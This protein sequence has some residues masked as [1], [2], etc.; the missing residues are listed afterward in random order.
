MFIN[1]MCNN[2]T[3]TKADGIKKEKSDSAINGF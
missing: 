3:K 2:Q 1:D